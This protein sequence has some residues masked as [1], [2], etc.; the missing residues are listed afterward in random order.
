MVR[1]KPVKDVNCGVNNY[2]KGDHRSYI[3]SVTFAKRHWLEFSA[4]DV[5]RKTLSFLSSNPNNTLVKGKSAA[6]KRSVKTYHDRKS[7]KKNH[8][9][10]SY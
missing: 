2:F 1:Y 6:R 4:N 9:N 3:L 10:L 5:Y 7:G 8:G